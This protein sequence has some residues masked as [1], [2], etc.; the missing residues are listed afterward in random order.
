MLRQFLCRNSYVCRLLCVLQLHVMHLHL[1]LHA[2]A[3]RNMQVQKHA[4]EKMVERGS[5]TGAAS[6]L[7]EFICRYHTVHTVPLSLSVPHYLLLLWRKI[8][9]S[10]C[11]PF[12][13]PVGVVACWGLPACFVFVAFP[14]G[15]VYSI[16]S[17]VVN[18]SVFW[19]KK[20]DAH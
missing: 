20:M 16:L 18:V 19:D 13:V 3:V 6:W 7:T 14:A 4:N 8:F 15:F 1:H 10:P 2:R 17:I 12:V 5:W 11:S 9:C